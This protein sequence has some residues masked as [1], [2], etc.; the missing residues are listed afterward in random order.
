MADVPGVFFTGLA[1]FY[2]EPPFEGAC[3]TGNQITIEVYRSNGA[4]AG[5]AVRDLEEE[6]A[7]RN[8]SPNWSPSRRAKPE[9]SSA[10]APK[11]RS[12]PKC[13]WALSTGEAFGSSRPFRRRW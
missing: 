10:S 1:F 4:L 11:K 9:A 13:C 6:S 12:S 7:S 2:P 8:W 3:A 5:T